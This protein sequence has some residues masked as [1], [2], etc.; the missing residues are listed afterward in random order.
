MSTIDTIARHC[1]A[2]QVPADLA[3][4]QVQQYIEAGP[5]H[6]APH[7]VPLPDAAAHAPST[8]AGHAS[9]GAREGSS[10]GSSSSNGSSNGHSNGH[11]HGN[12]NG[13]AAAAARLLRQ[14]RHPLRPPVR[15]HFGVGPLAPGEKPAEVRAAGRG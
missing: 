12:G 4:A 14:E 7:F 15:H 1:I 6:N 11:G 9:G 5:G 3:Q 13:A 10:A 2:T 8:S